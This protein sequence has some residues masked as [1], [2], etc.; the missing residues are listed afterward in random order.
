MIERTLFYKSQISNKEEKRVYNDFYE[1]KIA[2]RGVLVV[3]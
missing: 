2:V 3:A 1:I